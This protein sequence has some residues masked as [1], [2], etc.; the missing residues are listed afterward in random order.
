MVINESALYKGQLWCAYELKDAH[1]RYNEEYRLFMRKE[2][3]KNMF[4]CI[5]CKEPLI[6]CAGPVMEPFFKHYDN[7]QCVPRFSTAQRRNAAARRELYHLVKDSF[8]E[9]TIELNKRI[10][11]KLTADLY[12]SGDAIYLAVCYLGYEMQLEDWEQKHAAFEA[13]GITDVWFLNDKQYRTPNITTFEYLL[14]KHYP[15]LYYLNSD[16]ATITLKEL[17]TVP[18]TD[19]TA[20]FT[21]TYPIEELILEPNGSFLC[22][23]NECRF[24]QAKVLE[25]AYLEKIR[26]EEQ[27]A[28]Q[29]REAYA[30]LKERIQYHKAL[31]DRQEDI[32]EEVSREKEIKSESDKQ[33][34]IRKSMEE[35]ELTAKTMK[36]TSIQEL[37]DL[38]PLHGPVSLVK[39]AEYNRYLSLKALNKKLGAIED[40]TVREQMI[41]NAIDLLSIKTE[42]YQWKSAIAL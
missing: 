7:S 30:L 36:M 27:K 25:E 6:L 35:G 9:C 41:Q 39:S 11:E 10:D 33:S 31:Q 23:F 32:K 2:S 24:A 37:W 40:T 21:K 34:V 3:Q 29:R 8:P 42:A 16:Q 5:D 19:K 12:V 26:E 1:G 28:A 13:H 17:V 15:I 14:S 22:D 20:R 18:G 38:T 4:I